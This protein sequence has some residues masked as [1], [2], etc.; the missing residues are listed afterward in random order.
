MKPSFLPLWRAMAR[1]R[2]GHLPFPAKLTYAATWRCNLRCAFCRVWEKSGPE[3]SLVEARR[4]F[5]RSPGLRWLDVTGGEVF[6]REDAVD[7][8][9]AALA[10]NPGLVLLHFPTNGFLPDRT[11]QAVREIL[12]MRPPRL[13]ATVSVDG[14]RGLHDR[15]RGKVGSFDAAVETFRRLREL[16]GCEVLFGMTLS[17]ANCDQVPSTIAALAREVPGT[18]PGDLHLNLVHRAPHYYG[19]T[20]SAGEDVLPTV[21]RR[22]RNALPLRPRASLWAERAYLV[23]AESYLENGRRSPPLPCVALAATCFVAPDGMVY[24]C[25]GWDRPLGNLSEH[26]FSLAALWSSPQAREARRGIAAGSCP[27]CWTP[28]EAVPALA[29]RWWRALG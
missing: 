25:V 29:A 4:F 24:P 12:R 5:T 20:V 18:G 11:V 10:A 9:A 17:P 16:P 3:L 7:L 22:A 26:G 21:L 2:G 6:L 14:P 15:L 23:H 8:F 28:C 27:G 1:A 13:L 19:D